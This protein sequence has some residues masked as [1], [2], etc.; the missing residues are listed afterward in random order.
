MCIGTVW[1]HLITRLTSNVLN[2]MYS[3]RHVGHVK[4]RHFLVQYDHARV[5]LPG[6]NQMVRRVGIC[7]NVFD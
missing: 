4:L 3:G 7:E 6:E 2:S 1:V 5:R